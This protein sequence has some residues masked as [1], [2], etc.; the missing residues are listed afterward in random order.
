MR[1]EQQRV[2]QLVERLELMK[3]PI[4]R[5]LD[6]QSELGELA[7]ELLKAGGYGKKPMESTGPLADELGDCLFSLLALCNALGLDGE[8]A[9]VRST[10]TETRR[11]QKE[12]DYESA[13][14]DPGSGPRQI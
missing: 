13:Q 2:S 4:C 10:D 14:G 7:K 12:D 1:E 8:E 6:L 9:F 5:F 3:D 11:E